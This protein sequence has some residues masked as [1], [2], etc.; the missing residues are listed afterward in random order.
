MEDKSPFD[1]FIVDENEPLNKNLVVE[2]VS[3]FIESIGKNKIIRYTEK[4]ENSPAWLKIMVYLCIR[5][6]M[7]DQGIIVNEKAGPK[8]IAEDTNIKEG[9]AKDISRDKNLQK[10]V[11]KEGSKYYIKNHDLK[12]VKGIILQN[13]T[14]T[15]K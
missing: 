2:I 10:V 14:N 4:F 9:S 15:S 7:L 5:K 13:E 1:K 6:V 8:E 11:S 3:S 12:K